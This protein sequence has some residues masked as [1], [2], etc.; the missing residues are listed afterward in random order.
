MKTVIEIQSSGGFPGK[1]PRLR[2]VVHSRPAIFAGIDSTISNLNRKKKIERKN[3]FFLGEKWFW[4]KNV[5][6]F[7]VF[8]DFPIVN[9]YGFTIGKSWKTLKFATFFFQNHFSPRKKKFFRSIF[10]FLFKLDIVL[11]IP[12]KIAGRGCTTSR[13]HHFLPVNHPLRIGLQ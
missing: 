2:D 1:N 3:F 8:H 10:F 9:P 12:A 4:K 13:R 11:S 7:K 6:N 5:A